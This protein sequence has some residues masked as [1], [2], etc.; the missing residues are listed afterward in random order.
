MHS[1]EQALRLDGQHQQKH[2]MSRQN[3]KARMDLG[4]DALGHTEDNTT[5]Q[6]APK[7]AQTTND[8]GF[9]A[10]D[11]SSRTNRRIEIG[12]HAQEHPSDGNNAKTQRH[13]PGINPALVEAHQK[14]GFGII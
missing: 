1:R 6:R 14:C 7:I 8:H 10:E 4:T 13:G 12:A 9:K 3:L 2:Q 11:Q 5:N